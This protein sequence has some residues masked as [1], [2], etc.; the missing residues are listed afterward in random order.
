MLIGDWNHCQHGDGERYHRDNKH[1]KVVTKAAISTSKKMIIHKN[2][3]AKSK[4][5]TKLYEAS[6]I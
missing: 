3:E 6:Q 1:L 2:L 4:S 5:Y